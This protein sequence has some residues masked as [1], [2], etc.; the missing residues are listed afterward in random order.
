MYLQY[1]AIVILAFIF[2]IFIA[3][4]SSGAQMGIV[5]VIQMVFIIP[6][7]LISAIIFYFTKN[8]LFGIN[9]KSFF[10]LLPLI[11]EVFYFAVTKDLFS[12]F[13]ADSTIIRSYILS[14]SLATIATFCLNWLIL[15]VF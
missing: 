12:I 9:Y 11:I 5:P 6:I 10:I 3:T 1:I 15:K 13:K 4:S 7:F 8:T 14:I 2:N